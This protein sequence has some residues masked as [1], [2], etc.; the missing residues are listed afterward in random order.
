MKIG[1][2]NVGLS[3]YY[4]SNEIDSSKIKGQEGAKVVLNNFSDKNSVSSAKIGG[5]TVDIGTASNTTIY[6]DKNSYDTILSESTFGTG[7]KWSEMGFDDDKTWV[8]INGQRFEYERSQEE[9]S[10]RKRAQ[11]AA[12]KNL[13]EYLVD[14]KRIHIDQDENH[15]KLKR[16]DS[17]YDKNAGL[18]FDEEMLSSNKKVS[19]LNKN[20]EVMNM[21]NK[22][23]LEGISIN[24]WV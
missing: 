1:G 3:S 21:L 20:T 13:I 10:A 8:V 2:L 23:K 24:M 17:S 18:I 16:V 7:A 6:V 22:L 5:I 11:E 15:G 19:D 9:K 14:E 4:K 12:S